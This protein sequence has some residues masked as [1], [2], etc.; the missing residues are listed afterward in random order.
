V[1]E[2]VLDVLSR[3]LPE[4]VESPERGMCLLGSQVRKLLLSS[5]FH[6]PIRRRRVHHETD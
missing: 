1:T 2:R 3:D 6:L 5:H 4:S